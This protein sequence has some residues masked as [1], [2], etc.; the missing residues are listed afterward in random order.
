[1]AAHTVFLGMSTER[2]MIDL[3]H[4][5]GNI[6]YLVVVESVADNAGLSNLA[7]DVGWD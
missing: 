6:Y 3:M 7:A 1:M 5:F 4:S 2:N